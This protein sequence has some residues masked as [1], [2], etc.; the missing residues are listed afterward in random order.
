MVNVKVKYLRPTYHNLKEWMDDPK[1]VYIG[2]ANVV[3]IGGQRFPKNASPFSNPYKM[4]K[5]GPRKE[6]L[7]KYEAY[8]RAYLKRSTWLQ[9]QLKQLKGKRLG[10]WCAPDLCHGDVLVKLL[11]EYT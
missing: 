6:V 10:C 7:Q 5:D 11:K 9:K 1:N 3:F 8:I 2:R 4:G